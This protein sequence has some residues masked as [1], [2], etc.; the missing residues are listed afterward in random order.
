MDH[1]YTSWIGDDVEIEVEGLVEVG[2]VI[3]GVFSVVCSMSIVSSNGGGTAEIGADS[4]KLLRTL[5]RN[6]CPPF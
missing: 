1:V 3:S 6:C 4:G 5:L 2:S